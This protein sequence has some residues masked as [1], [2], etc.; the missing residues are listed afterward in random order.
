MHASQQYCFITG[1][2]SQATDWL[3][4]KHANSCAV[5]EQGCNALICYAC[6]HLPLPRSDAESKQK[7]EAAIE[8]V[9]H[10]MD[11]D[12]VVLARSA[13]CPC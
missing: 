13:W 7:H 1:D 6:R 9:L 12:I 8:A 4:S 11:I 5:R 3:L 10:E 2:K